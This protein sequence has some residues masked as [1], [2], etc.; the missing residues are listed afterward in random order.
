[1]ERLMIM[2]TDTDMFCIFNPETF[3]ILDEEFETEDEAK[4]ML[5]NIQIYNQVIK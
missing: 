5:E 4:E 2:K 1:M 3:Q